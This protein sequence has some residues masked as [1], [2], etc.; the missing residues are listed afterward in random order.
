M[1][2]EY[3]ASTAEEES[4]LRRDLAKELPRLASAAE[5][6]LRAEVAFVRA[7]GDEAMARKVEAAAVEAAARVRQY[8]TAAS[9]VEAKVHAPL[10][11]AGEDVQRMY[12]LTPRGAAVGEMLDSRRAA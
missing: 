5:A 11:L 7:L 6:A 2:D 1:E 9:G 3:Y 4:A 12:L 8:Q 10:P